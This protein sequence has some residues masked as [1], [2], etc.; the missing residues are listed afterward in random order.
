MRIS[1]WSSDVCSSDLVPDAH[2]RI[3]LAPLDGGVRGDVLGARIGPWELGHAP[4]VG[5][6]RNGGGPSILSAVRT[7]RQGSGAGEDP[8]AAGL[9]AARGGLGV[10]TGLVAGPQQWVGLIGARHPA[11]EQEQWTGGGR[12]CDWTESRGEEFY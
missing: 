8:V 5:S 9:G 3:E 12:G 10:A 11:A 1:D 7:R 4:S 6:Q 2:E